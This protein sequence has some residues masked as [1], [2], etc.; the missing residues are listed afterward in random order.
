[1][2]RLLPLLLLAALTA[3]AAPIVI[4]GSP[5]SRLY[6]DTGGGGGDCTGDELPIPGGDVG[7][8]GATGWEH[9]GVSLAST[10]T[11]LSGGTV[12]SGGNG[13]SLTTAGATYDGCNF[14]DAVEINAANITLKRS[15]IVHAG[16]T[17]CGDGA[18]GLKI[19]SGPFIGE[20]IEI[21]T[22]NPNA[23]GG[24]TRLDRTICLATNSGAT[25]TRIWA[26]DSY[27]GID[28]TGQD[29]FTLQNSYHGPNVSPP[30]GQAPGDPWTGCPGSERA[31]ASAIRAAGG[32]QDIDILNVV[33]H[34]GKCSFASGLIATYPENGANHDWLIDGGMWIIEEDNPS[35]SG[36]GSDGG[37]AYGIAAGCGGGEQE[38][39]NF[40]V[41]NLKIS[42]QYYAAACPSGCAQNWNELAGT[43]TWSN[44][45]KYNPGQGDDG[46]AITASTPT[47]GSPGACPS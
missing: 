47:G 38:N 16:G 23:V 37:N 7:E 9:T 18:P 27:R 6:V 34:I 33:L 3:A 1:M 36:T 17:E 10:G 28:I 42:T 8:C 40:I 39:Y 11:C 46:Q 41:Q 24:G 20:D 15:R 2:R 19:S 44:V 5:A 12:S 43:N 26:H 21:A 31:H 14:D 13:F 22:T 4:V 30:T 45:T 35:S 25:L 32:T 29:N